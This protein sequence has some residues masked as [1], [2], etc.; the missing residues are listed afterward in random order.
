MTR[1]SATVFWLAAILSGL[2]A[3]T[4]AADDKAK[5]ASDKKK[6]VSKP[7]ETVA[8][9]PLEGVNV[10]PGVVR[11]ANEVLESELR[12]QGFKV[13]EWEPVYDKL[14]ETEAAP[15]PMPAPA[16]APAPT[17]APAVPAA[18]AQPGEVPQPTYPPVVDHA[19]PPPPPGQP[20]PLAPPPGQT[21][22]AVAQPVAV[23]PPAPEL[24]AELKGQIARELEADG[25]FDGSLVKL[26]TKI[27]VSVYR[28]D[29]DG[30][31]ID[32]RQMEAKTND[33][34]VTV[35]ERISLAFAKGQTTD[36]TLDLDNATKAE[37]QDLPERFRLEKNF[38][39][40]I[41]QAFGISDNMRYY[42]MVAFDARLEIN[43]LLVE[44]NAGFALGKER[45]TQLLID[46]GVGYYLTHTP[47]SPYIGAG[48]GVFFGDRLDVD[49]GD[50]SPV[51]QPGSGDDS[52]E[53]DVG[54][55]AFPFI[56][57][58][59]LRHS[60]IRVHFDI[61][62]SFSWNPEGDF[63]HGPVVLVGINF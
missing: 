36:E 18:P 24:S 3:T 1:R 12:E 27:R 54:F 10:P 39:A 19:T 48:A 9:F 63:G 34:L 55:D 14:V 29:L 25:Y 49:D 13:V 53:M 60:S 56:G 4:G 47:V 32:N 21:S 58:E 15:A 17:P 16:P 44:L 51:P 57:L 46:I 40:I 33:D 62:Y 61:R 8:V 22:V 43:D 41:G 31:V 35:L 52:D 45:S 26:G 37:T 23:E 5:K 20:R 59:L 6:A 50:S 11:A 28:R 2:V 42:T 38:G 30:H 7:V